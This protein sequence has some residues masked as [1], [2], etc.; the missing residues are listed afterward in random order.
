MK[1]RLVFFLLPAWLL[2][3]ATTGF[4]VHAAD[5]P[6]LKARV[7]DTA[8]MFSPAARSEV[9][10]LLAEHEKETT[11]QVVVVTVPSLEGEDLEGYSIR[12]A[13]AWKIGQ[14][15]KDNGVI[16]LFS[17]NDRKVRIEV[18]YGL[19]GRLT[20][21]VCGRIIRYN[22]VPY[23]KAGR[24]DEGLRSGVKAVLGTI[25]GEYRAVNTAEPV[26]EPVKNFTY[27]AKK[28]L[29]FAGSALL[30][31]A[32]AAFLLFLL[33]VFFNMAFFQDGAMGWI[34]FVIFG[35]IFYTLLLYAVIVI[36]EFFQK[37]PAKDI[38]SA[39]MAGVVLVGMK[40]Y[41][42]FSRRGKSI[43]EKLH[44]DLSSGSGGGYSSG[45]SSWSSSGSSYSSSGSSSGG[46]SG[47]GGSFGGGGASGGW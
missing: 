33:Y 39:T 18:G 27:Y 16:L 1:R 7:N 28:I 8:A 23:F 9:E 46:Y 11:D 25:K 35:P 4:P 20:D 2:A 30:M 47:G 24:F 21:L 26:V 29:L 17:K 43:A 36:F 42:L 15:G 44:M 32:A 14:K 34:G 31:T 37:E 45:S 10:T 13:E 19:E 6:P 41:F 38:L 12:L 3:G 40:I 5:I 22:I